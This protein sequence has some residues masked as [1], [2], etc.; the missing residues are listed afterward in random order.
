MFQF[1]INNRRYTGSKFKLLSWIKDGVNSEVGHFNSFCDLFAGTGC[2]VEKFVDKKNLIINDFLY[3]NNLIYKAFFMS[4]NFD[5]KKLIS[6]TDKYLNLI[7]TNIPNN[8]F[9]KNFGGKFFSINDAKKIGFIRE[10]IDKENCK[11]IE[12][13]ILIASLLY[14]VDKSANT[15]GHYDAFRKKI[16]IKGK[17]VFKLIKPIE[18]NSNI[19]IYREDANELVKKIKCDVCYIDPPYNS[20]Q[21][22]RFYHVLENLTQWK[23]PKLFGEALK[24]EPE[25][26]SEYCKTKAP[27]KFQKLISNINAKYIVLSYNNTYNPKSSSSKNKITLEQIKS[28][29]NQKGKTKILKKKHAHFN[30]GKT[31]F[32]DHHEYLFITKI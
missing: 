6:L 27:E 24:P 10:Q 14:S 5:E 26:M 21:Y 15:V 1:K 25:N 29:L 16:E 7:K 4:K 23:K 32:N 30:A 9:S 22:S 12:K 28:I 11:V 3:S 13:N 8:Y 17:F 2:V 19:Q 18:H 20:R 31:N